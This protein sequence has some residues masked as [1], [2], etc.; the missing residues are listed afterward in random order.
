MNTSTLF[1][2]RNLFYIIVLNNNSKE[3]FDYCM[4]AD[5]MDN[6]FKKLLCPF[7]IIIGSLWYKACHIMSVVSRK[8]E[9]T[10]EV[11]FGSLR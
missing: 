1:L 11:V 4:G 10:F 6:F 5:E 3:L 7:R 8:R 2:W 9:I